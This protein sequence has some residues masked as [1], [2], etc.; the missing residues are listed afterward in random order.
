MVIKLPARIPVLKA[1]LFCLF[2]ALVELIEGTDPLYAGLVLSFLMLSVFA[3][4]VAGGFNRPSGAYIFYYSTLVAGVGTVYNALLGQAADTHLQSPWLVMGVYVGT[5]GAL[6]VAAFLTRKIATSYD[7]VA[8][9]LH[10]PR[11]NFGT[12][13][14]GCIVMVF[15]ITF[16]TNVLPNASGTVL[17]AVNMVNYFLPL[18][19]LLGTVAAVRASGGRRST[20][21]LTLIVL[22]YSTY[23]GLLS[24][25]KQGMFTPFVCWVIGLAWAR[26]R[27]RPLHLGVIAIFAFLAQWFMVP[28]A[29]VG[30]VETFGGSPEERLAITEHYVEHPLLLRQT[31]HERQ[32]AYA[33]MDTWYYGTQQGIFDRLTMLPNDA[34]LISFSAAGNYFGYLPILSYYENWVPHILA[35]HKLEGVWVGGNRYAHELGEL[36]EADTTTGI[37]FSPSGE[38]FHCDGWRAVLLVQPLIFLLLFVATD[39]VCGDL[40]SQPW[41]L[42]PLLLFAHI[43]PEQLLGGTIY[44]TFTGNVGT[45]FAIFVCGYVAPV[46]GRLLKGRDRSPVWRGNL[47]ASFTAA[48]A[49]PEAA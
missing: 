34:Q 4:N 12:S 33:G 28:L 43:A 32:Q 38:A 24:F 23:E 5:A 1:L 35:P 13:A 7:G 29:N 44:Y 21:P 37:S 45:V 36:A 40:R 16:I 20:S 8:G 49:A 25:S 30:R 11:L 14:M 22:V 39:G 31:N 42:L 48:R 41:G 2:L 18:S 17:H 46:F 9:I 47:S 26:F 27:L 6:L 15:L 10:V 3:F 19:I